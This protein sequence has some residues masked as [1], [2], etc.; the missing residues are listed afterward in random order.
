[1]ANIILALI[2]ISGICFVFG[3][4][5]PII[6]CAIYKLLGGKKPLREYIKTL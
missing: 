2:A 6:A 5:Y 4:L 3:V 1:M